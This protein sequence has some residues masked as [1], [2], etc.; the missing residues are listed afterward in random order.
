[1]SPPTH[2]F[3]DRSIEALQDTVL[4]A[5]LARAYGGFVY[6]RQ[7]ALDALPEFAEL[8]ER[9][10]IIKDHA[11]EHL[12]HHLEGFE[13]ALT[14]QGGELHWAR[15]AE[16]ACQ[17]VVAICQAHRAR[18]ITKGKSM[19]G[20]EI[21]LNGAL[22]AS[23]L[24]V[25]ETDLGEYIIQLAKEPPSH[26]IAPAVHK[27]RD[28]VAQLFHTFHPH[29]ERSKPL[30][31]VPDIVAEAR[32]V[33]RSAF[34]SADV[35]ITGANFLVAETG[36]VVLVTN[37]G[38]GDL[39]HTLPA[40]HIVVASIEK[41]VPTLED[42][43]TL[44]R[45]LGRSATGQAMTS[46]TTFVTGPRRP[47]DRDGP[48]SMH[49]VL[50][51]NGRSEMLGSAFRDMLRCIRC[52]ACL[53]HCP[54]YG[55]I[56]GHAYGWVYPGPMGAVLTPRILGLKAAPDLPQACTLN[57]RC[58][59][60][61]PVQIPLPMLLRRLRNESFSQRITPS[62][63]R[64]GLR[65]WALLAK[66]PRL[67]HGVMAIAAGLLGRLGGRR[68]RFHK[69]PL[70]HGWTAAR[71]LPAPARQTFHSAWQSRQRKRPS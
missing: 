25:V 21:A 55:A 60:V 49:V 5:A 43:T 37:E 16:E 70:S 8:C 6:K 20:E 71:D 2:T 62:R 39:V 57:G 24:H 19:V 29:I 35:G 23:G 46:Y 63:V 64:I 59:E 38:N 52:G 34:L 26:I 32:K 58:E 47:A 22:E 30:T 10:R 67:Y 69:L 50:V 14:A 4:Q 40:V 48:G 27:T 54:V 28:Q 11:L 3:Q 42:V 36:S 33:L 13:A 61:C 7:A 53:N 41:I 44:L 12:D 65:L 1:M 17:Q 56:G 9:A 15:S 31:E 66:H 18:R 51:D 68:G 45:V